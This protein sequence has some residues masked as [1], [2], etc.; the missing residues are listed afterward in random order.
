MT[1]TMKP[2]R[3]FSPKINYFFLSD[4]YIA[5]VYGPFLTHSSSFKCD[6]IR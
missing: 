4:Y 5:T 1:A 3:I 6:K 2:A